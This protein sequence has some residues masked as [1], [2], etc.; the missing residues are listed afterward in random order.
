MDISIIMPCLNE[1]NTVARCVGSAFK[2]IDKMGI[3][4]EVIVVDNGSSDAS[5]R[6]AENAGAHV[7]EEKRQ[8][9]GRALR[10]GIRSASGNV[11]ILIDAD[12]TY[13]FRDIPKIYLPLSMGK[14]DMVIGDRFSGGIKKGAMSLSHRLGVRALSSF[15]RI[16]TKSN[17][18]DFH[19]GLRGLTKNAAQGLKFKT[20]GM[21]FA[22]EMIAEATKKGLRIA[23]RPVSLRICKYKRNSKL[24]TIR[25]GFRHLFYII[26]FN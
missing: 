4:G 3:K 15:G 11:L 14:A 24:R 1:E 23:Q 19:C 20:T 5:A 17:V 9:Y 18:R 10:K 7:I 16:K 22:T 8:G 12:T 25:D 26:D 2:I 13:D 6:I 21:E